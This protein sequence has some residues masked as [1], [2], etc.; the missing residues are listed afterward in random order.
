MNKAFTVVGFYT[1]SFDCVTETVT[2]RGDAPEPVLVARACKK[3]LKARISRCLE[4]VEVFEGVHQ[5]KMPGIY[6]INTECIA[7]MER[8]AK[9]NQGKG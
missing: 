4:I 1:E 8:A 9:T 7:E 6:T 3:F 2:V 5:S